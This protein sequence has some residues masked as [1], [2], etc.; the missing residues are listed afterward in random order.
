LI[1]GR[2]LGEAPVATGFFA[3]LSTLALVAALNDTN[4]GL[5][6]ALMTQ[7]GRPRDAAAYSVMCLESGPFLTMLTLGSVAS[8]SVRTDN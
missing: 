7:Y 3:G 6:M 4:G 5:Y 8:A 1:A 2:F